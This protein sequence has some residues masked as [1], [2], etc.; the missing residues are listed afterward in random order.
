[1]TESEKAHRFS[2]S[3]I[4]ELNGQ[5]LDTGRQ[6]ISPCYW[7]SSPLCSFCFTCRSF[8]DR[9]GGRL[10]GGWAST[11]PAP[12]RSAYSRAGVPFSRF[13]LF[14]TMPFGGVGPCIFPMLN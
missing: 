2:A 3:S 7:P 12:A 14:E 11:V 10:Y 6:R 8:G 4:D 9:D 13:Q 1:M 5:K